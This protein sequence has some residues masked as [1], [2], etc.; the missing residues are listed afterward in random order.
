[1]AAMADGKC[2]V[3]LLGGDDEA[4]L[5][6]MA[7]GTKKVSKLLDAYATKRPGVPASCSRSVRGG[8]GPS[9]F[10]RALVFVPVD[11]RGL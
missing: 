7:K 6:L 10:V 11:R 9:R 5:R 3:F 8:L 4:P 2:E 1:M